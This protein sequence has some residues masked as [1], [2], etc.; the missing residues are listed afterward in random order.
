MVRA[1]AKPWT[2]VARHLGTESEFQ[3]FKVSETNQILLLCRSGS[4]ARLNGIVHLGFRTTALSSVLARRT[5]L[6]R[7]ARQSTF[8]TPTCK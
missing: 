1:L 8:P 4:V 3:A 6:G 5:R 7:S 2:S